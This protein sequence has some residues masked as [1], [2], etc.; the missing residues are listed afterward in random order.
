MMDIEFAHTLRLV[1]EDAELL[2]PESRKAMYMAVIDAADRARE[3]AQVALKNGEALLAAEAALAAEREKVR[4]AEE[5]LEYAAEAI[6]EWGAYAGAY[7]QEKHDL[8]GDVEKVRATLAA[9]RKEGN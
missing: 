5:A 7:F 8:A 3:F 1:R 2:A 4:M 9:I 6:E